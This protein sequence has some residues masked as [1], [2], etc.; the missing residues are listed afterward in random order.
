[1][2][3]ATANRTLALGALLGRLGSA[4]AQGRLPAETALALMRVTANALR[5]PP[6]PSLAS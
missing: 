6:P 2:L 5:V 4:S 3:S 1:M